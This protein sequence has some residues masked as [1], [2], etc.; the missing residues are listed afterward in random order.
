MSVRL[1]ENFMKK[2]NVHKKLKAYSDDEHK[3]LWIAI[4]LKGGRGKPVELTEN[5][6]KVIEHEYAVRYLEQM[7]INPTVKMIS[8]L[9]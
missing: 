6:V 4:P 2:A 3:D 9:L 8:N 5:F 1:Y 7:G